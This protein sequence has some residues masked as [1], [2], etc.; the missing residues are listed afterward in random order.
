[1]QYPVT[2]QDHPK[3]VDGNLGPLAKAAVQ[4]FPSSRGLG[5]DGTIGP[6]TRPRP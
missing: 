4:A 5:A 3:E 1:V 6:H 2:A